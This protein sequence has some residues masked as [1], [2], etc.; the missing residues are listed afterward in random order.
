MLHC[1]NTVHH[2]DVSQT[3]ASSWLHVLFSVFVPN[4]KLTMIRISAVSSLAFQRH[5]HRPSRQLPLTWLL[6][7]CTN[8]ALWIS[9]R[10]LKQVSGCSRVFFFTFFRR[11]LPRKSAISSW[12]S[13]QSRGRTQPPTVN[14]TCVTGFMRSIF[15]RDW[16][17]LFELFTTSTL[18]IIDQS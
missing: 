18:H 14:V 5:H 17:V 11:C 13:V 2:P 8:S 15:S 1:E 9:S 6:I 16:L 4:C 10:D 7:I 3:T 12:V